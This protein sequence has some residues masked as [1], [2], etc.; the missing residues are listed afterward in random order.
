MIHQQERAVRIVEDDV[1]ERDPTP[2]EV[3]KRQGE[4]LRVL[5]A[6]DIARTRASDSVPRKLMDS[7]VPF[8]LGTLL[9][10]LGTY[11]GISGR[12][13]TLEAGQGQLGAVTRQQADAIAAQAREVAD[14]R[15]AMN[16]VLVYVRA[17]S[18]TLNP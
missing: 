15:V 1:I 12:L 13:A 10:A 3:Y 18:R 9:G 5:H 7:A 16:E 4:L 17:R 2:M 14:V 8:V 6:D 11:A